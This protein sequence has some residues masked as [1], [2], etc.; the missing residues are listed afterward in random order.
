LVLV[1]DKFGHSGKNKVAKDLCRTFYW[2]SLWAYVAAHCRACTVCQEY[3][4]A[5]PRHTPTKEREVM[6]V[7]ILWGLYLD[8][9]VDMNTS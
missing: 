7:P 6:V 8:R 3:S 9:G 5:T 4:K 1:H 2:P